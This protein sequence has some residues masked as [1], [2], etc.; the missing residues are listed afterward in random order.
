VLKPRRI[1]SRKAGGRGLGPGVVAL[2][3]I[4]ELKIYKHLKPR[5]INSRK[6]GE[7]GVWG[8]GLLPPLTRL[9]FWCS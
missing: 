5:R 1:N 9:V 6:A 4:V 7:E 3:K 2:P 8:R